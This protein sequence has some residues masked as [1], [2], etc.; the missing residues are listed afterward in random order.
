MNY[1]QEDFGIL[2]DDNLYLDAML[3]KQVGVSDE[4]IKVLRVWVPKFPL[5]KTSVITCARQ[6]IQSYPPNSGIAH[7][8]FDLRGT[9]D[10]DSL[11]GNYDYLTDLRSVKAW[12]IERFGK[13]NFGLLGF[14]SSE[15]G[16]VDMWPLRAGSML[17]TYHYFAKGEQV[18]PPT[19]LYLSSYG[20]FSHADEKRCM[21]LAEEGY[22]V[23]GMDPYRYLLSASA[24]QRLTPAMLYDDLRLLI[25]MLPVAPTIIAEPMAA[26]LGLL[27]AAGVREVKGVIA[28]GRAQSGLMPKHI[29]D[30]SETAVFDLRTLIGKISPRPTVIIHHDGNPM[31][32][33]K[34]RMEILFEHSQEPHRLESTEKISS[35]LLLNLLAWMETKQD[36]E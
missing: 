10:S 24:S 36:K 6:E 23:Y 17:E 1:E 4:E 34:K 9:G 12:A 14:P 18:V 13:I 30:H 21:A 33:D 25:Q 2:T 27:W 5:T 31:G 20:N 35:G 26:G 3:F 19:V 22:D 7:L 29:F 28:I 32:G 8:V 11:L 16:N 15:N